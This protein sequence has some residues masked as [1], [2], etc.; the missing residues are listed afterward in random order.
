MRH[1]LTEVLSGLRRN[2]SMN[3]AVLV[4]MWVSLTLFGLGTLVTQQV[5]L[6][7]GRWYDRIEITLFLCTPATQGENCTPGQ[8]T[9]EAQRA[10]IRAALEAN[11]EVAEVFYQSQEEVFDEFGETYADSPILASM[12]AEDMQDLFRIKLVNP[13]EYQIVTAEAARM[14]GVQN[15]QDLRQFLDPLFDWLNWG[16]WL[17]VGASGLLLLAAALQIG[18]S[19]R[20]AAHAR[21]REIGIMRLVGASNTY[22]M[23]PFLLESLLVALAGAA[24]ACATL[25]GIQQFAIVEKAKPALQGF[26]WIGWEHVGIAMVWLVAVAIA[27]SMIPTLIATR[28]FLKV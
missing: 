12:K 17:A 16:R 22:I 6:I 15:V 2:A 23:L 28:R 20:M 4:T 7:K 26:T 25:A 27:L 5:D 21:R 19:I 13:E 10:D 8:A 11:P 9:T 14:P 24:L 3:L 18:N 1:A